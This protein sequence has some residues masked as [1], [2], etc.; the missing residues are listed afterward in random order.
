MNLFFHD[1][2]GV[3]RLDARSKASGGGNGLQP[4]HPGPDDEH[5]RGFQRARGRHHHGHGQ[6]Q[7]R[8]AKNHRHIPGQIRL[9]A[10]GIHFLRQGRARDQF[11]A[12]GGHP[13]LRQRVHKPGLGKRIEEA[14]VDGPRLHHADLGLGGLVEAQHHVGRRQRLQ[15]V[16][17][18][19]RARA[20][21]IAVPKPA[22]VTR[23]GLDNH[24]EPFTGETRCRV[25]EQGDA[26]FAGGRFGGDKDLH[27]TPLS[28][29][30]EHNQQLQC[31]RDVIVVMTVGAPVKFPFRSL[32][33]RQGTREL[34]I[35]RPNR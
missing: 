20:R 7:A 33:R 6:R 31:G 32:G 27:N 4:G 2:P 8:R 29:A 3:E 15:T 14:D 18:D 17:G 9:G 5:T 25:G 34:M 23:A 1:R 30:P 22:P 24:F 10:E 13:G 28:L 35:P 19:R 26:G 12:Q 11:H 21:V 16:C